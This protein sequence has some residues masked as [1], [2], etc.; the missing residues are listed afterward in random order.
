MA[1]TNIRKEILIYAHWVGIEEPTLMGI[2]YSEI[3][4]G[5]EIFSFEYSDQWLKSEYLQVLDPDLQHYSGIQYV[6]DKKNNFG[7][8]LD[9]SPDRWGQVLMKR[10][11]AIMARE[12]NRK[13]K[14]LMES[15]FLLGVFD[16][17]RVGGLRFKL[18]KDGDFLNDDRKFAAPPWASIRELQAASLKIEEEKIDDPEYIKWLNML[19][20]PG[21][22]LGGARPKASVI[23][24]KGELWIAKF[25]SANDTKDIGGWEIVVHNL[26]KQC[27]INVAEAK[28]EKYTGNYHT[29][30]IKRFDR[31]DQERIHFASAMT[32]LG[33]TDNRDSHA[34]A[35]Y[36]ELVGFLNQHG[37]RVNEDLDELWKRIVFSIAVS[38]TDDHLRNHGFILTE[39]GWIIS[40]AFD[41]NPNETGTGLSL[42]ISETDNSLNFDLALE[43]SE[44]FRL[45]KNK[46]EKIIKDIKHT[47]SHWK[48]VADRYNIPKAEHRTM[49]KAFRY[50]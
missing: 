48:N 17:H 36:L 23:D 5:Q 43:V 38:N 10:R 37:A 34:G 31:I 50:K 1:K 44:Y 47:V 45:D 3:T 28:V 21:S 19:I 42:N 39:L 40:P 8:F 16:E 7:I 27:G 9:S 6:K 35:S 15:D 49:E 13:E 12:E 33:Y 14:T 32:M 41:I 25:P 26:A 30:M 4:K 2:L 29:F 20:A 46:A 22:S 11:E 24:E 18:N